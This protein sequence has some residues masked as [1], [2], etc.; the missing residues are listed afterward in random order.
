MTRP[1][2][3]CVGLVIFTAPCLA[4]DRAAWMGEARF[5]VMNHYL[6]DWIA[7]RENFEGGR[8]SVEQWNDLVDRFDVEAHAK[9]IESTGAKYQICLLYT[10]DAADE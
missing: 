6:A 5:G 7:R 3:F 4:Q 10:S 8:I 2:P 9:Q 1:I